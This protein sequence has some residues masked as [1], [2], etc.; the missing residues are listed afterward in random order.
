[1]PVPCPESSPTKP[2][3]ST[4]LSTNN[5]SVDSL[6]KSC[7]WGLSS[8]CREIRRPI[9]DLLSPVRCDFTTLRYFAL[10]SS[11]YPSHAAQEAAIA[12]Y[13]RWANRRTR[14]KQQFA[15]GSRSADPITYP[16]LLDTA[17]VAC[18]R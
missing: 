6:K 17:L 11:D 4:T 14:P 3:H 1:L 8:N 10:D 16:T 15:I 13:V 7:T 18:R 5:G 2:D 9:V 12:G